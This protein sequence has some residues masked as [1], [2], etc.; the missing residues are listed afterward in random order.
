MSEWFCVLQVIPG[1]VYVISVY[2]IS[3]QPL[4]LVRMGQF[5]V[6]CLLIGFISESLGLSISSRLDIVVSTHQ[7]ILKYREYAM[8]ICEV[9]LQFLAIKSFTVSTQ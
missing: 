4:E 6:V 5:L 7:N 9:N 2:W 1:T 8:G 3:D